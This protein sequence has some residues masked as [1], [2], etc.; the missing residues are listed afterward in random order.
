MY[1]L[2]KGRQDLAAPAVGFGQLWDEDFDLGACLSVDVI[3]CYLIYGERQA[4]DADIKC[5][6]LL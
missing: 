4:G 2:V 6:F 5:E 3:V 1:D